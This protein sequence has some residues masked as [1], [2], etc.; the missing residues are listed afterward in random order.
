MKFAQAPPEGFRPLDVAVVLDTGAPT[1][2]DALQVD[3]ATGITLGSCPAGVWN[4]RASFVGHAGGTLEWEGR[5][6]RC[7]PFGAGVA[8]YPNGT[9]HNGTVNGYLRS[10]AAPGLLLGPAALA[11]RLDAD[12]V[13]LAVR[14][15]RGGFTR[16]DGSVLQA[17]FLRGEPLEA[18]KVDKGQAV[19]LKA[20]AAAL[21]MLDGQARQAEQLAVREAAVAQAIEA[22]R[23]AEERRLAEEQRRAE[24][25]RVMAAQAEQTRV[26][27]AEFA[28]ALARVNEQRR[29]FE[30]LRVSVEAARTEA[31]NALAEVR[32]HL[33][34]SAPWALGAAAPVAGDPAA[35]QSC[36]NAYQGQQRYFAAIDGRRP[37][38]VEA[39]ADYQTVIYMIE[40]RVALL[41]K[42]CRGQREAAEREPA[43]AALAEAQQACQREL[44]SNERC[45]GDIAW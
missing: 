45:A 43:Q 24:E 39:E 20:F 37:A 18:G 42:V 28:A 27:Q 26:A 1:T 23:L 11:F 41:D 44:G 17:E 12:S 34:G 36:T 21:T 4:G 25:A 6:W 31:R 29:R 19:R 8:V 3:L 35:A 30:E 15:G 22:K 33:T 32:G 40:A 5:F 38:D 10:P 13:R 9:R 16:A 14:E 7:F 2:R